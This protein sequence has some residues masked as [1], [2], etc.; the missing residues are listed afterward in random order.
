ML[1][2]VLAGGLLGQMFVAWLDPRGQGDMDVIGIVAGACLAV[3]AYRS[4]RR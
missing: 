2:A 3:V 4:F 1:G